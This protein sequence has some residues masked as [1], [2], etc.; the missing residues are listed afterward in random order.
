MIMTALPAA[1]DPG[2]RRWR[3]GKSRIKIRCEWRTR[4]K[5]EEEG[6]GGARRKR[7]GRRKDLKRVRK[8][9]KLKT[10]KT[11]HSYEEPCNS[12]VYVHQS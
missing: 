8:K 11:F 3:K 5:E 12:L 9:R 10:K 7:K 1:T 6:G 2:C 4:R